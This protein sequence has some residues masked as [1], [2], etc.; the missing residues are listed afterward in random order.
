MKIEHFCKRHNACREGVDWAT[1]RGAETMDELWQ[2]DWPDNAWLTWTV[3]RPGVAG[4]KTLRLL[5]V[6]AAR[7][8]EH[9]M[10]DQRIRD[11]V[12]VAER[13]AHGDATREELAAAH[14]AAM[15]AAA[16]A[17]ARA[18][19]R[20]A[21]RAAAWSA[22]ARAA[23]RTAA[24]A[25]ARAADARAADE[26]YATWKSVNEWI[27]GNVHPNFCADQTGEQTA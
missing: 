16:R 26:R 20:A 25:A 2:L 15:D 21:A 7:Q 5:A 1:S 22:D 8:V 12:G 13:Y 19:A 10:T 27:K 9:L 17:D 18:D 4:D 3:T 6:F 24:R 23:V 11:V 14:A